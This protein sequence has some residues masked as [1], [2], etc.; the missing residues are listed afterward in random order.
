M[1]NKAPESY[2][3]VNNDKRRNQNKYSSRRT[4]LPEVVQSEGMELDRR[5]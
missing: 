2:V 5:A 4:K 1:K 3:M